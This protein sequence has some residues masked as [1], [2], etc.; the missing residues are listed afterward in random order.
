MARSKEPWFE[1]LLRNKAIRTF[2]T[3][4]NE[5]D[6]EE[7]CKLC[8]LYGILHLDLKEGRGDVARLRELVGVGHAGATVDS[9]LPGIQEKLAEL[10]F[11]LDEV[12]SGLPHGQ[13]PPGVRDEAGRLPQ[14]EPAFPG[15]KHTHAP[16]GEDPVEQQ[17]RREAAET[18][19][20]LRHAERFLRYTKGA[21]KLAIDPQDMPRRLVD[22]AV[23]AV[24]AANAVAPD[25][26]PP[27]EWRSG[28][29]ERTFSPP[30]KKRGPVMPGAGLTGPEYPAW[31]GDA[32]DWAANGAEGG[33]QWVPGPRS[34]SAPRPGRRPPRL[35]YSVQADQDNKSPL[36][37]NDLVTARYLDVPSSGYGRHSPPRIPPQ[38]L[39]PPP[40]D[41]VVAPAYLEQQRQGP[42]HAFGPPA[43][44]A[45]PPAPIQ[46]PFAPPP[47]G[48]PP[49][50]GPWGDVGAWGNGRAGYG[51]DAGVYGP[52]AAG[53]QLYAV[54]P[55]PPYGYGQGWS[56]Q[57]QRR[58]EEAVYGRPPWKPIKTTKEVAQSRIREMVQADKA[59]ARAQRVV[60]QR[61]A[62]A[63][64]GGSPWQAPTASQ[65]PRKT[66]ERPRSAGPSE[67]A[68]SLASNPYTSW[69][70]APRQDQAGQQPQQEAVEAE[71]QQQQQEQRISAAWGAPAGGAPAV[72]AMDTA[73]GA[74]PPPQDG[75]A[76]PSAAAPGTG[77]AGLHPFEL[78]AEAKVR[79]SGSEVGS[80]QRHHHQQGHYHHQQHHRF[81]DV[82]THSEWE[83]GNHY[84]PMPPP[85]SPDRY[86]SIRSPGGT[87]RRGG[88]QPLHGPGPQYPAVAE[89]LP[90]PG[91]FARGPKG[92]YPAA[93]QLAWGPD[94]SGPSWPGGGPSSA[95]WEDPSQY[96][97]QQWERQGVNAAWGGGAG[98]GYGGPGSGGGGPYRWGERAG[99]SWFGGGGTYGPRISPRA[100]ALRSVRPEVVKWSKTWVGDF[101]H[102]EE[103][104]F[105]PGRP[106]VSA[107][108]RPPSRAERPQ[109][110][111]S[112][113]SHRAD[114]AAE[115]AERAAATADKAT[116]AATTS[117]SG[118]WM[119]RV[120]AQVSKLRS[121]REEAEVAMA[122]EAASARRQAAGESPGGESASAR[123]WELTE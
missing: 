39:P 50:P 105:P 55:N 6:W 99:G 95:A 119:D 110:A 20:A 73:A 36:W 37:R 76:R 15:P 97:G 81:P 5:A 84:M 77:P 23:A 92:S 91:A 89:P 17:R 112:G 66:P 2:L 68:E 69:F 61:A 80:H 116:T 56:K 1:Y 83:L 93:R 71:A 44:V 22:R 122:M 88:P 74:T 86:P 104:R 21:N 114:M 54:Y 46:Q 109:P 121:A 108:D 101:G 42:Q 102:L 40:P 31:W 60:R 111:E 79:S 107:F 103:P 24:A 123:R 3:S 52:G 35:A 65:P 100:E 90:G 106:E 115:K 32:T 67:V 113:S 8:L 51:S 10:K 45:P 47:F 7:V 43:P 117:P 78:G 98:G 48:M 64:A 49:P 28:D 85:A 96:G 4:Y 41:P 19:V 33:P 16:W 12:A 30:G 38:Y 82:R 34:R 62:E 18:K 14:A 26:R 120:M 118:G 29:P 59:A 72:V 63:A 75:A 53:P 70:M 87:L 13:T 11:Q 94:A 58:W 25:V 9:A 57:A 27:S